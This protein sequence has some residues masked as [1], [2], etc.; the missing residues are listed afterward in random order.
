MVTE[1]SGLLGCATV[2]LGEW[3]LMLPRN[4]VASS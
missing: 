3:L 1:D 4:V 2:L